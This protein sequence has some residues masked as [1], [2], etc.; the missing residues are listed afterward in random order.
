[1]AEKTKKL[2]KKVENELKQYI[3][4]YGEKKAVYDEEKKVVD[5]LNSS[6][7]NLML[8]YGLDKMEGTDFSVTCTV[9]DTS[10]MNEDMLLEVI[11]SVVWADKGSMH[12]PF[13]KTVE[14]VDFDALEKAMYNGEISK[15]HLA[16]IGKCRESKQRVTLRVSKK[17]VA[18]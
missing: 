2:T 17:K 13:I 4:A 8:E 10:E 14:Q 12:C 15:E 6:I 11:K 3:N 1:M 16:E 9:S 7:K 5:K 18:K